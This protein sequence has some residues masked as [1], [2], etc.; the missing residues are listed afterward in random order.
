[1]LERTDLSLA[2]LG[3][4]IRGKVRDNYRLG[5]DRLVLVT[6]DR[7][8]AFD[9]VLG[10]V[11]HK[12]QVLNQLAAWWFARTADLVANHV[13]DVPDPNVTVGRA[14]RALPVEV[15]V[16]GNITGV[17]STSL[18]TR[19]AAG[20]RVIY[21]H[22]LPDGLAKDDLLAEPLITPTTKALDGGHDEP[23]TMADVVCRGLVAG[24]AWDEVCSA[25]L[26]VVQ[27]GP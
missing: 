6:T 4:V 1:M 9:R 13:I 18:W 21:G 8:S 17:T 24:P 14:C 27:P 19:Y 22:R 25:A 23:V 16:R 15:V 2:G 12:G 5:E 10:C 7:L 11:P 3:P 26:G 20:D